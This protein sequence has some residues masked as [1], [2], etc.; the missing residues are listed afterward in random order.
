MTHGVHKMTSSNPD[1]THLTQL[2]HD[3]WPFESHELHF[4]KTLWTATAR[5]P[6]SCLSLRLLNTSARLQYSPKPGL[7]DAHLQVSRA[8]A[9]LHLTN[10]DA[11]LVTLQE[12]YPKMLP[13]PLVDEE[14]VYLT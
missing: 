10:V 11:W 5:S 8:L 2:T 7:T 3:Y 4:W 1:C 12:V 9:I 6:V 14:R 13:P